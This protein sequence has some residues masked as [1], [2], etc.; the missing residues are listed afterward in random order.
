MNAQLHPHHA[1]RRTVWLVDDD[2]SIRFVLEKAL[3]GAGFTVESFDAAETALRTLLSRTPDLVFTDV[4]MPGMDGMAFMDRLRQRA[5]GVP[6]VVMS[7]YTD[8]PS[9][10]A[11]FHRG[12]FDYLPKPFD[13]DAA[14]DMARRATAREAPI[15][16]TDWSDEGLIGDTPAMREVFRAIGRLSRADLSVLIT[17]ETG[18]GK[19]LIARALHR[20]SPRAE[21][22]FIALNTAAI[23]PELLESELFGH[24][25]G[26]FTGAV[27]RHQGRFEQAERGTLFLDEIGDMPIGLQTRLLRVLAE[28]EFYRVGGREL[29]RA[30]VRVIAATHQDLRAKVERGEFR[31]DLLHRLDVMRIHL[32]PLRERAADVQRLAERFLIEAAREMRVPPKQLSQDAARALTRYPWPGNVR[33]L[34]NLCQR[35]VLMAPGSQILAGDLPE[36]IRRS[37]GGGV[38]PGWQKPLAEWARQQLDLGQPDLLESAKA[39]LEQVLFDEALKTTG[40]DRQQAAKRLGCGRNTLTRK[41]GPKKR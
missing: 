33:E 27:R 7:A 32:P 14:I 2:R 13:I 34:R 9:T 39:T 4:R 3:A 22:P 19:E 8:L 41:L 21:G 26:A 12:A 20:H 18:S 16:E 35:L 15:A 28:G 5:A 38:E 17:G 36:E 23:A 30:D 40:G 31:A 29:I 11:A 24:E 25:Q 37:E 1:P 10:V 6:V